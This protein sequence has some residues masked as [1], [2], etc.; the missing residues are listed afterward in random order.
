MAEKDTRPWWKKRTTQGMLL[1]AV[2]GILALT[3]GAP[4]IFTVANVWPV[5]SAMIA[6][7]LTSL[8]AAWGASG[9]ARRA[10][11]KTDDTPDIPAG[12]KPVG[13]VGL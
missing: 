10:D 1:S 6:A 4:V 12:M 13:K 9:A 7:A 11:R 8:G 2:G 5:T 3:P